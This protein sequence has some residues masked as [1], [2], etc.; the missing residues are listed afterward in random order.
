MVLAS[1]SPV[2]Q[3]QEVRQLE[4]Q[5]G[6]RD[7]ERMLA[8]MLL[9]EALQLDFSNTAYA[10]N[11]YLAPGRKAALL[12][13]GASGQSLLYAAELA[14]VA[15]AACYDQRLV[16]AGRLRIQLVSRTSSAAAAEAALGED[17]TGPASKSSKKRRVHKPAGPEAL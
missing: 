1:S 14:T 17:A 9:E 11:T 7:T 2:P 4:V 12:K 13:S 16:L 10:T 6:Q 8:A 15:Q 3:L 5:L